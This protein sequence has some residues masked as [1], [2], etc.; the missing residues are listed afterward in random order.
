MAIRMQSGVQRFGPGRAIRIGRAPE[1]ECT[2]DDPAVSRLHAVLEPRP[3]GWWLIDRSTSGTY[4]EGEPVTQRLINESTEV[5]LGHPTAGYEIEVVPVLDAQQAS[6]QLAKKKQEAA[7]RKRTKTLLSAAAALV[8]LGLVGGLI[9]FFALRGGDNGGAGSTD[10]VLTEAELNRAKGSSVLI[11]MVD[12]R[13]RQL[14][15]GSGSII[16]SD[17]QI[18]TNAHVAA[19]DAPGLSVESMPRPAKYL[20]AL[21]SEQDDKPYEPAF[22][23]ETIVAD[24]VL[25]LAVMQIVADAKGNPID[26]KS[27]KLPAAMPIGDSDKLRTGDEI[28]A[29]GFPGLA[30]VTTEA[31]SEG[32]A[33]T[34]TR[35]VVS[36]FLPERGVSDN[37]AWIDSD[38]RI[39]SGNSGGAS[40]N[41]D[42]E[43]IGIN[44]RGVT[45]AT[46]AGSGQ[47]GAFTGGSALIRP[48]NLAKPLL[49]VAA[50]G[51][52]PD[53]VSPYYQGAQE[54]N[55]SASSAK[56]SAGG[57]SETENGQCKRPSGPTRLR[58]SAPV[59]LYA[60]FEVSGLATGTTVE[61]QEMTLDGQRVARNALTWKGGPEMVCAGIEVKIPAGLEG[62]NAVL[63]VGGTAVE[64]PVL[65]TK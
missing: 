25:D 3:D 37:R 36:T 6:A 42:G 55:A 44:T 26:R 40:V 10:N 52:D 63:T 56:I 32:R 60:M 14:G 45:E 1:M 54:Q 34:V 39:G 38:I 53:Y 17:G 31:T 23:A 30:Y 11:L 16:S 62:I 41:R 58:G 5:M 48:V 33:L 46:V 21:T 35:G 27:L 49:E 20:V 29:L 2:A 65:L 51:G 15:H 7:K 19:M 24:G 28:T 9:T 50:K 22:T 47:G 43:I 12:E 4:V 8:V 13:G 59:T 64:N 57:W 61:F 18:L